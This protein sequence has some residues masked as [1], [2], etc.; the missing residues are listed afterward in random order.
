MIFDNQ[1]KSTGEKMKTSRFARVKS[2]QLD[3][4]GAHPVAID[5]ERSGGEGGMKIVGLPDKAVQESCA[6]VLAALRN[7]QGARGDDAKEMGYIT[8]SLAP[9][10]LPKTGPNFDLPIAVGLLVSNGVIRADISNMLFVGELG[11]S[12]EVRSIRGALAAAHEARRRKVAA[13]FVPAINAKEAAL[14]KGVD[15]Y[16]VESLSQLIGHFA[17]VNDSSGMKESLLMS[18]VPHQEIS[19]LNESDQKL[20]VFLEI[21]GN[22]HAKRALAIAAAG[23]HHVAL[24]G[25]PGTGKSMLA[26][27]FIELLPPLTEEELI[28]STMIHSLA[29]SLRGPALRSPPLRSPHHTSSHVA[30]IGGGPNI[31]PGEVTLAH[32]G[33]LFLDEFPEFDL[34]LIESLREPLEVGAVN[35]SR[36]K[37]TRTY[38]ARFRMI[39]A[40]N[41]CPCGYVG[42]RERQCSCSPSALD[43]YKRKLSGP[44][45]DRIDIWVQVPRPSYDEILIPL[46][47]AD[48]ER[49]ESEGNLLK[50]K[51]KSAVMFARDRQGCLNALLSPNVLDVHAKLDDEQ[52][53]LLKR[54]ADIHKLSARALHRTMRVARTIADL[55]GH[56][57]IGRNDLLEALQY[58]SNLP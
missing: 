53:T 46:G 17:A 30:I 20:D 11:L 14:V 23:G 39:A 40:M 5:V 4:G 24:F 57:N 54:A 27:S 49:A 12:G 38:P 21:R 42:D 36:A 45:V 31:R 35:I 2:L 32:N 29:G 51:I 6:R 18:P 47:D 16:G 10:D 25:P 50:E 43:K 1:E 58:R 3:P 8:V 34:K 33:V 9:A 15:I 52:R 37:G 48:R 55:E 28:E 19:G 41:P 26:R 13:L 44:I 56:E 7:T 22:A